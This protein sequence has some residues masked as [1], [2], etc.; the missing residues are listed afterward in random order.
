M[1]KGNYL[2]GPKITLLLCLG[3]RC[4]R[5]RG[6]IHI[7]CRNQCVPNSSTTFSSRGLECKTWS[8]FSVFSW[9]GQ[10]WFSVGNVGVLDAFQEAVL[11]EREPEKVGKNRAGIIAIVIMT[12]IFWIFTMCQAISQLFTPISSLNPHN[13]LRGKHSCCPS[14]T[15]PEA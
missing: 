11:N 8:Q 5:C 9:R 12:S 13:I 14:F 4:E 15:S 6:K 2:R 10:P 1:L 7:L 3:N